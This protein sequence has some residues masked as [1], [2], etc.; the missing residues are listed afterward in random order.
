MDAN[1]FKLILDFMYLNKVQV[2]ESNV[3]YL[4]PAASL[5]QILPV[6][7]ACADFLK[8][9]SQCPVCMRDL[10]RRERFDKNQEWNLDGTKIFFETK[11]ANSYRKDE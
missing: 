10:D 8:D 7:E 3:Q 1:S 5:L 4:L 2:T 11:L 6:V 9:K